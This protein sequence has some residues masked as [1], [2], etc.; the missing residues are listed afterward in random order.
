MG[1]LNN[2]TPHGVVQV[3]VNRNAKNE[4]GFWHKRSAYYDMERI[5]SNIVMSEG[6][7]YQGFDVK[8]EKVQDMTAE[9]R[10]GDDLFEQVF[11]HFNS[12]E[13]ELKQA[14]ALL[15]TVSLASAGELG[16]LTIDGEEQTSWTFYPS[17]ILDVVAAPKQPSV[18]VADQSEL[19]N[20]LASAGEQARRKREKAVAAI[21]ANAMAQQSAVTMGMEEVSQPTTVEQT[22]TLAELAA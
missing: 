19:D 15:I 11:E 21:R 14:S 22:Q 3:R 8:P 20:L 7:T 2:K 9:L 5:I 12:D 6:L 10:V 17:E 16:K 18:K 4:D 13:L 1:L